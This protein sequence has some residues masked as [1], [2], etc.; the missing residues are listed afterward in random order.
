M[1][2]LA[3][4]YF[5]CAYNEAVI[6]HLCYRVYAIKQ[7]VEGPAFA[8]ARFIARGDQQM[9]SS[10]QDLY[11]LVAYAVSVKVFLTIA[12]V[13]DLQLAQG[14]ISIAFL[15]ADVKEDVYLR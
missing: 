9:Q 5:H 14:D 13:E 11:A 8:K 6:T 10:F 15:E 12:A 2:L 4:V 3:R 7:P 1:G